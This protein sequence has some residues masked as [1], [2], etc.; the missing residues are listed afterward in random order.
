MYIYIVFFIIMMYV[1]F[2]SSSFPSDL[3]AEFSGTVTA[4]DFWSTSI[5][6]LRHHEYNP[7]SEDVKSPT[8]G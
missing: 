3:R 5:A 4:S 1:L 8:A 2:A 7:T 6:C